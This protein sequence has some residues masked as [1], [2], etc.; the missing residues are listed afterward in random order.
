[1]HIV[2]GKKEAFAEKPGEIFIPIDKSQ[3]NFHFRRKWFLY[4]NCCS[5]ST[6]LLPL[7]NPQDE[8]K[9]LTIGVFEAAVEVW[10]FQNILKNKNSRLVACDPWAATECGKLDQEFMDQAYEN[11]KHNTSPWKDQIT[12]IRG[13]S[14]DVLRSAIESG[15]G[16]CGIKTFDFLYI[17]GAHDEDS[18]YEDFENCM[19]LAH[20]GSIVLLDDVRNRIEKQGHVRAGLERFLADRGDELE[21]VFCHRFVECYRKI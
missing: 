16:L 9:A 17:D 18:V 14:E 3:H 20:S 10:L 12:L 6:H 21:H 8:I 13:Y 2:A 7:F 15:Q 1:M 4:R 19:E 5:F 11:A